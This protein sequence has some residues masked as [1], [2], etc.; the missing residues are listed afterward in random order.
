MHSLIMANDCPVV[1][2][3]TLISLF[4]SP[5]CHSKLHAQTA[6]VLALI[7]WISMLSIFLRFLGFSPFVWGSHSHFPGII[8]TIQI[9][10]LFF[11]SH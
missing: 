9:L 11:F 2:F 7:E 4:H 8:L 5:F 1:F 10:T 3:C 6:T